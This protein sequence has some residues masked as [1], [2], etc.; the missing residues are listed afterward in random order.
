MPTTTQELLPDYKSY[1][2]NAARFSGADRET[3]IKNLVESN[4]YGLRRL[5]QYLMSGQ[6]KRQG[7]MKDLSAGRRYE[8]CPFPI[9]VALLRALC[10][11][12]ARYQGHGDTKE[13]DVRS[14]INCVRFGVHAPHLPG[15]IEYD[16]EVFFRAFQGVE[17]HRDVALME[18]G[19]DYAVSIDW[20]DYRI[21][22]IPALE[23][24][25]LWDLLQMHQ[26]PWSKAGTVI[27]LEEAE[28]AE[29]RERKARPVM[30][31]RQANRGD[32]ISA[33]T[34]VISMASPGSSLH[35]SFVSGTQA[36]LINL[37][38]TLLSS[39]TFELAEP[40][41]WIKDLHPG[42]QWLVVTYQP[43]PPLADARMIHVP[44]QID[45]A[46]ETLND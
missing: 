29:K 37:M 40:G 3:L 2:Y 8:S 33:R 24:D 38:P 9:E 44:P 28:D 41:R 32:H 12:F 7:F 42:D 18:D 1:E 43:P 31:G 25:F 6:E 23:K 46:Q 30:V 20:M 11:G 17:V 39:P 19:N 16:P 4:F 22:Q 36:G 10:M 21:Y 5:R 27:H 35:I 15:V 34:P 14:F 45:F 13:D 26:S